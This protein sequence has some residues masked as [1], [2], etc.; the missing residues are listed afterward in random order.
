MVPLIHGRRYYLDQ[1]C[2]NQVGFGLIEKLFEPDLLYQGAFP[3]SHGDSVEN[4]RS[5]KPMLNG[6]TTLPFVI[7]TEA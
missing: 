3:E 7:P 1:Q 6:S 2:G 4:C 5:H